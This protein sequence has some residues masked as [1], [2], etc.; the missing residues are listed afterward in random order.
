MGTVE[1]EAEAEAGEDDAAAAIENQ[2]W[3]KSQ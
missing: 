3:R 1:K 2:A